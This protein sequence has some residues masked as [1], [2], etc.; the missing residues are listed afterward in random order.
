MRL[1]LVVPLGGCER[2][3]DMWKWDRAVDYAKIGGVEAIV[4]GSI[5]AVVIWYYYDLRESVLVLCWFA[6]WFFW[7]LLRWMDTIS[8]ALRRIEGK[9]DDRAR[10]THGTATSASLG[11]QSSG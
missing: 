2:E 10:A 9:L 11:G 5:T 7:T 3:G 1:A 8:N 4:W 6:S